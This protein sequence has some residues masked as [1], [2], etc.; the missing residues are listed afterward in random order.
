[1]EHWA[2]DSEI[3][4]TKVQSK[5]KRVTIVAIDHDGIEVDMSVDDDFHAQVCSSSHPPV[6]VVTQ[7]IRPYPPSGRRSE[8]QSQHCHSKWSLSSRI[9]L[10]YPLHFKAY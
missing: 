1:M 5:G 9:C 6:Y 3:T 4:P 8:S 7:R 2:M 10:P